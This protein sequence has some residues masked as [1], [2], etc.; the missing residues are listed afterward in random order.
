MTVQAI[1]N[2]LRF[3][4]LRAAFRRIAN[5]SARNL[6]KFTKRGTAATKPKKRAIL[7]REREKLRQKESK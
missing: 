7:M 2:I 4:L 1:Q 6:I 3:Q 5:M